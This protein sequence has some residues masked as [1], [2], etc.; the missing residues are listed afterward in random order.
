MLIGT[1]ETN[2]AYPLLTSA[3]E[4]EDQ[5]PDIRLFPNPTTGPIIVQ[6]AS[7]LRGK[8]SVR[9]LSPSGQMIENVETR[10]AN[11]RIELDLSDQ[12][13]GL[14]F[15]EIHSDEGVVSKKLIRLPE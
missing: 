13:A 11:G 2:K 8:V 5:V 9:L 10:F 7:P 12:P 1:T 4:L 14:Y 15:L 3:T 6:P